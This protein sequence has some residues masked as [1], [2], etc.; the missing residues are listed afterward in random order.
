M[1]YPLFF[2]ENMSNSFKAFLESKVSDY[3]KPTEDLSFEG[4][5]EILKSQASKAFRTGSVIYRGWSKNVVAGVYDPSTGERKSENTSNFY[6]RIF[7]TNPYNQHWPK[8]SKSFICTTDP[9]YAAGFAGDYETQVSVVFPF[10]DV[11]IGVAPHNDIWDCEIKFSIKTDVKTEAG[12]MKL[13]NMNKLCNEIQTTTGENITSYDTFIGVY[14]ALTPQNFVDV[15]SSIGMTNR[16]GRLMLEAIEYEDE[17]AI[18]TI[19]TDFLQHWLTLYTFDD[20]ESSDGDKFSLVDDTNE[21]KKYN[22]NELW[23]AGKC[24]ICSTG[25]YKKF[26]AWMNG[27]YPEYESEMGD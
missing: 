6:T 16:I 18:E 1:L 26:Q 19:K 2:G 17:D 27:G 7:D 20:Y 21:L 13:V 12:R 3:I 5:H 15:V 25:Y 9:S 14:N 24:L 8:R 4:F 23:F 11:E 22:A 10:D